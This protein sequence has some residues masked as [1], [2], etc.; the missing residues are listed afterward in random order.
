MEINFI[1]N[2]PAPYKLACFEDAAKRTEAFTVT[3]E[4]V[5]SRQRRWESA[6]EVTSFRH[7]VMPSGFRSWFE[8]LSLGLRR[9]SFPVYGL[10]S[11]PGAVVAVFLNIL[12]RTKY[13]IWTSSRLSDWRSGNPMVHRLKVVIFKHAS[14]VFVPG[15]Q[16]RR[17]AE[18]LGARS[19]FVTPNCID[20]AAFEKD[21]EQ[22]RRD[23]LDPHL[24]T[25]RLNAIFVGRLARE[26]DVDRILLALSRLREE[27]RGKIDVRIVGFGPEEGRLKALRERLGLGGSVAFVGYK[28][29]VDLA[30]Y[31]VWADV[32]LL[33][34]L[35]EV[36]GLVV[37]EALQAGVVPVVSNRVGCIPELVIERKTGFIFEAEND[38]S[39]ASVLERLVE[40][41]RSLDE[42]KAFGRTII[43]SFTPQCFNDGLFKGINSVLRQDKD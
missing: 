15:S 24:D 41:K 2:L 3:F 35:S 29:G 8:W 33:P 20:S 38:V 37:N 25:G 34:S 22:A 36:W 40:N 16:A 9:N 26:K 18:S 31:Y 1:T 30:K 13:A 14:V 4:R 21:L 32:L 42:M 39:L 6:L 17:Y 19:V 5:T 10:Y 43:R 23:S 27:V 28:E 7:K 12:L 11:V